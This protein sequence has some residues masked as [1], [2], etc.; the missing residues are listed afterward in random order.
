M[1]VRGC[2]SRRSAAAVKGFL[3]FL[4]RD[5]VTVPEIP[6]RVTQTQTL[7]LNRV[8]QNSPGSSQPPLSQNQLGVCENNPDKTHSRASALLSGAENQFLMVARL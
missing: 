7:Y 6:T 1:E 3:V 4:V 5:L 2:Y 8:K